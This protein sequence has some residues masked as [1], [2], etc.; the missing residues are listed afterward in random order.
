MIP[1]DG[2][3]GLVFS[4]SCSSPPASSPPYTATLLV[5]PQD[6]ADVSV[7]RLKLPSRLSLRFVFR[8]EDARLLLETWD[9]GGILKEPLHITL[10]KRGRKLGKHALT[11]VIDDSAAVHIEGV[12]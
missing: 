11:T 6:P 4:S 2:K 8:Q 9:A 5:Q 12:T 3:T 1:T 7:S 10:A